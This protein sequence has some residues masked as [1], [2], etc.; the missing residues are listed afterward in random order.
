MIQQETDP[1]SSTPMERSPSREALPTLA[2]ISLVESLPSSAAL[3]AAFNAE[4]KSAPPFMEFSNVKIE[5]HLINI[6]QT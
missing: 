5:K 1:A 4:A 3:E 2:I 6:V